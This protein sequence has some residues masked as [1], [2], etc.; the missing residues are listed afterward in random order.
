MYFVFQARSETEVQSEKTWMDAERVWLVHKGGFASASQ[1]KGEGFGLPEGRVKIRLDHGGE[2]LEVDE[3][4]VEKVCM[5]R[6][7]HYSLRLM[8]ITCKKPTT[9]LLVKS[10]LYRIIIKCKFEPKYLCFKILLAFY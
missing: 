1:L 3:D 7:L 9:V 5:N 10:Q 6:K 8:L 4:D 2:I